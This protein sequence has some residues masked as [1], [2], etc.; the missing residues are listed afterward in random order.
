MQFLW[1]TITVR[2][3]DESL[4]FYQKIISL[5]LIRRVKSS[6]ETELAFL[7]SDETKVE[8]IHHQGEEVGECSKHISLG[9]AVQSLDDQLAF[10][11]EQGL[12]IYAGPFSPNPSVRF[13]YILDPN[14]V[15]IQFVEQKA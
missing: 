2:D 10:I 1:T 12:D 15:K 6:E 9:F 4:A 13:F 11:K 5:P 3:M 7:G 14:G 8:L